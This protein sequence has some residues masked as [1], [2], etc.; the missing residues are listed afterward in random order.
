MSNSFIVSLPVSRCPSGSLG[1]GVCASTLTEQ[2]A[3]AILLSDHYEAEY[4]TTGSDEAFF[5]FKEWTRE[6]RRLLDTV[7]RERSAQKYL[8]GS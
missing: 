7:Q 8:R 6:R 2:F 4:K 3:Q 1:D 5:Y